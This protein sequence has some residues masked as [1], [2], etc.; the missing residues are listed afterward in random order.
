MFICVPYLVTLTNV[1]RTA[2][3]RDVAVSAEVDCT[4]FCFQGTEL[5]EFNKEL[6]KAINE[7]LF[8]GDA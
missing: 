3:A 5:I 1:L 8:L 2:L 7:T 4:N 6:L